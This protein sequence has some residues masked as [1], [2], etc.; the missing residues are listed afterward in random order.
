MSRAPIL[1]LI[2]FSFALSSSAGTIQY[3]ALETYDTG[4]RL[5]NGRWKIGAHVSMTYRDIFGNVA[6]GDWTAELWINNISNGS[7]LA[8]TGLQIFRSAN[9]N[10]SIEAYANFDACYQGKAYAAAG[11]DVQQ[12]GGNHVCTAPRPPTDPPTCTDRSNPANCYTPIVLSLRGGYH[13]TSP[14]DGVR[15][16]IDA[17][18]TAEKIA[19]TEPDGDVGFLALDRNGNG[20]IDSGAELFGGSTMLTSGSRAPNGFE[21]LA[22]MDSNRDGKLDASDPSWPNLL[23]WLDTNHD[24]SSTA[25]ELISIPSSGVSAISIDYQRS[26]KKDRFGNE[27]RYKGEFRFGESWRNCYDVFLVTA[28]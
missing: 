10:T 18:G 3:N 6:P 25:T 15:F 9:W 11:G 28:D 5:L 14:A 16:D 4:N 24:G 19:W 17:D 20:T 8:G 26:G 21:A 22:D 27:F 2:F 7:R 12:V 1:A 13:M 23:L